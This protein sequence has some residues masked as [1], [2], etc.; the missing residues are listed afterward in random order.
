MNRLAAYGLQCNCFMS[1]SLPGGI[2]SGNI[3]NSLPWIRLERTLR[4]IAAAA[5]FGGDAVEGQRRMFNA[6]GLYAP[7]QLAAG[8]QLHSRHRR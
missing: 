5:G 8:L 1:H 3:T 6:P 4:D 7:R 2:S